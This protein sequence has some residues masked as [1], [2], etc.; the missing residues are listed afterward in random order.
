MVKVHCM[1]DWI[2]GE[3]VAINGDDNALAMPIALKFSLLLWGSSRTGSDADARRLANQGA[4]VRVPSR[5]EIL[6]DIVP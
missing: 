1:T 3:S 4:V 6:R 5:S 2:V